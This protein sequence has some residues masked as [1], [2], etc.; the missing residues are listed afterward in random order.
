MLAAVLD[1]WLRAF[2]ENGVTVLRGLDGDYVNRAKLQMNADCFVSVD[3]KRLSE[4]DGYYDL[5]GS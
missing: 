4:I 2:S 1:S 3:L 5:A